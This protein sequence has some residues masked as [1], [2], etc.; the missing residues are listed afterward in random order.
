MKLRSSRNHPGFWAF[1]AHRISG[2][3]LALF[4]P[5]HFL[6]LGTAM[7]GAAALDDALAL[8]DNPLVRFAEWG[9]VVLLTVHLMAGLRVLVLEFLPWRDSMKR[10]IALGAAVAALIGMI[11]LVQV[12]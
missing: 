10:L 3:A 1:A 11:F 5:V 2:V 12:G 8:T 6:L 9:L 7:E 4:L